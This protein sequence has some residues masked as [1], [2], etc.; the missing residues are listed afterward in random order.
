SEFT[1]CGETAHDIHSCSCSC[2]SAPT[3]QQTPHQSTELEHNEQHQAL[4]HQ[5]AR[6]TAAHHGPYFWL[7]LG[8]TERRDLVKV[9][10]EAVLKKM[11]EQQ[12]HSC[13]C[14]V[15]G[16]KR[17]AIEE[18]LEVLYDAYYEELEQYANIQQRY[19]SSGGTT[20]PPLGPGP[21]PGSVELDAA[22]AVVNA[23][24]PIS[25]PDTFDEDPEEYEDEDDDGDDDDDEDDDDK[26]NGVV[27]VKDS[28]S[29]FLN[30]SNSLTVTA[31]NILTVADDLL[32]NDGQKFLEM[33]EQLAEH[34][35]NRE[36]EAADSVAAGEDEDED[37]EDED[38]GEYEDDLDKKMED[39]KRMFSIFAARMFEQ[40]VLTAYRERVAQ[41]RQLQLLREL[42]D[43]DR[44][45]HEREAKKA[46]ENQKKKDKKRQQKLAK[47]SEK[48]KRDADR[49]AEEHAAQ[50][51]REE[52]A[53][54]KR[55][56][57]EAERR[58][59]VRKEEE[60]KRLKSEAELKAK[61]KR[62]KKEDEERRKRDEE[63]A[64]GDR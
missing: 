49:L 4:E 63:K 32:K 57:R 5:L 28:P 10:R 45:A 62:R 11:K 3:T 8:E 1:S 60:R 58:E 29:S 21:F 64:K 23:Q 18:E 9:E 25:Q 19:V 6:G 2:P 54:K 46:K 50:L 26:P 41:E 12:K 15:C 14:A 55:E 59:K 35:T 27:P 43:E 38:E 42:E 51:A 44:V 40:R 56:E 53:R 22:G 52:E 30:F 20:S 7:G 39:G 36:D 24:R 16:R 37:D 61:E 34:R 48:A 47:D 31:G 33:M 17:A 13:A